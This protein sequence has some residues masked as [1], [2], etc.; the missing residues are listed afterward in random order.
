MVTR[1]ALATLYFATNGD[2]WV[3]CGRDSTNC[4][5]TQEWLTAENECDW[6]A[7]ECADPENG[8]YSVVK[9][10]FRK[11]SMVSCVMNKCQFFLGPDDV[12]PF[13]AEWG[14]VK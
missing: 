1:Y 9:I 7:I 13:S 2:N 10:F 5:V 14:G 11:Y 8:D 4:D 6:Y 12:A 3:Q